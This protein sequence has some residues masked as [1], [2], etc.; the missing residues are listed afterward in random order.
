M[1]QGAPATHAA[2]SKVEVRLR[3]I[4]EQIA[5]VEH[6]LWLVALSAAALD[7]YLTYKGLQFGLSEGNPVMAALIHE[8]GIAALALAKAV[9]FA[10]AGGIRVLRP[11][12]GPWLPLGLAIPWI[13]AAG[14]NVTLLATL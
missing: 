2:R 6:Q 8:S 12:W 14:I 1:S 3:S 9:L 4:T 11:S 10:V 5:G 7:V 13:L